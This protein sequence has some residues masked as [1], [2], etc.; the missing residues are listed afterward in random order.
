MGSTTSFSKFVRKH[1]TMLRRNQN[2]QEYG[3]QPLPNSDRQ[4]DDLLATFE[5]LRKKHS[6]LKKI[7]GAIAIIFVMVVLW[8]LLRSGEPSQ[9]AVIETEAPEPQEP[10][11]G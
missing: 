11:I 10:M 5:P 7:V 6:P 9:P 4:D 1:Q 2:N 8:I 3:N